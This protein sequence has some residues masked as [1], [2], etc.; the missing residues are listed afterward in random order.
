M[1][2]LCIF[3][4]HFIFIP[5]LS[6]LSQIYQYFPLN[7][8]DVVMMMMMIS[9]VLSLRPLTGCST[10]WWYLQFSAK[11]FCFFPSLLVAQKYNISV[12]FVVCTTDFHVSFNLHIG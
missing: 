6:G 12:D 9:V 11:I 7:Q 4:Y 10:V 8:C 1:G 5:P 2:N 3:L